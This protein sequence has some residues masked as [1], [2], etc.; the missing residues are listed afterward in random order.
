M[1]EDSA[2]AQNANHPVP[3]FSKNYSKFRAIDSTAGYKLQDQSG[4]G[5]VADD[6]QVGN[7]LWSA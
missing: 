3:F 5:E 6:S 2:Q 1:H 4:D 7:G